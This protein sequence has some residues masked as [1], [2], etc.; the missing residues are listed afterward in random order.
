MRN[1]YGTFIILFAKLLIFS[2]MLHAANTNQPKKSPPGSTNAV[3]ASRPSG[4]VPKAGPNA[5]N[6]A[7]KLNSGGHGHGNASGDSARVQQLETQITELRDLV[8]LSLFFS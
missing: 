6:S 5:S 4:P 2:A 8:S 7:S 1:L 3:G